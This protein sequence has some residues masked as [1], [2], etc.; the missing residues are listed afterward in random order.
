MTRAKC[1]D[2]LSSLSVLIL[3]GGRGSR[4]RTAVSDRPKPM[5]EVNG[6][7]FLD[8]IVGHASRCGLRHFVFC[9]GYMGD[10]IEAYYAQVAGPSRISFS[11]ESRPLGTAGALK[12]AEHLIGSDPFI[13]MN[14]DSFCPVDLAA[15]YKFHKE[16]GA[17]VSMV[18][19]RMKETG[20]YGTLVVSE[21]GR[22]AGYEEKTGQGTHVSAGIYCMNKEILSR[23][24]AHTA[25]SLERDVFPAL[26]CSN[27]Y[28]FAVSS[29]FMDIGT[30]ERYREAKRQYGAAGGA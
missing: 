7:P 3:A 28:A 19:T 1:Q 17:E 16:K 18:V 4:L 29:D 30:P 14:G 25:Y 12:H 24:P 13:V 23:I 11:R 20:D 2:E 5:A 15:F 27:S 6:R 26:L 10:F 8:M 9:T 21:A 22:I